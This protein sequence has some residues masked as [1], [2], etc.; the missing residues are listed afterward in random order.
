MRDL[1][2]GWVDAKLEQVAE[3]GSGGTPS[4]S[5]SDF[6][7]GTIPWIKTGELGQGLITDSEEKLTKEALDNSSAKV[8]PKGSVAIAMYGATIGKVAALGIDAATNQA[9]AVGT[10]FSGVTTTKYLFHYLAS[11]KSEFVAKGQGGAQPNISQT[12]IKSWAI[13][14]APFREQERIAEKLDSVLS[15]ID[16]CR[17]RLNR[18]PQILKKFREA[19]LEAA[20]SGRLTEEWRRRCTPPTTGVEL[21]RR[22]IAAHRTPSNHNSQPKQASRVRRNAA[23]QSAANSIAVRSSVEAIDAPEGWGMLTAAEVVEPDQTIIYGILQPGPDVPNGVPYVQGVDIEDGA[24]NT[25]TLTR[26]SKEIA[27]QY[28][29]STLASGDVVLCIIRNI[30]VAIVPS[31]L[32]GGNISRTIARLRPS[33]AIREK[34]LAAV[35]DSPVSRRWFKQFFRGIDMPGL[36]LRDVRQLPIPLP[37]LEEQDEI[38]RRLDAFALLASSLKTRFTNAADLAKTLS[39]SVLAKAFRG[40]LVPQDPNDEPAVEMLE[41]MRRARTTGKIVSESRRRNSGEVSERNA[42]TESGRRSRTSSA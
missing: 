37:S 2:P 31:E 14:V 30:K 41:R 11:Q 29:R 6:Y 16:A 40:E 20:V 17:S 23:R 10:P 13:P 7:G 33:R 21:A 35:L 22:A 4:R 36:N 18:V 12:I 9:C 19:V 32:D 25:A 24:I 15:R 26:T 3:W 42:K 5:R 39:P 38:V 28:S 27:Q 1:P 34:Y 8:F